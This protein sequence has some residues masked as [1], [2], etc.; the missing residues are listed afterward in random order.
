MDP[1]DEQLCQGVAARSEAAFEGLV[2]RYRGRAYRVAW[3]ILRDAEAARDVSQEAFVRLYE[4]AHTFDNRARFA[5]WFY[6]ILVRCALDRR[7]H[8]R[9][10]RRALDWRHGDDPPEASPLDQ[11]PASP[12]DP[13][14]RLAQT[15][16]RD[17]LWP[18]VAELPAQQRAVVVLQVQAELS[19]R[20]IAAVLGCREATVRVHLHR[21][22]ATLRQ[23]IGRR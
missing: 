7:R 10:W 5:T 15:E 12:S 19:T 1:S 23:T 16:W 21:A 17:R 13:T 2:E 3:L 22:L 6:R 4:H 14:D 9:W 8:D 20:D 18:A 11:I